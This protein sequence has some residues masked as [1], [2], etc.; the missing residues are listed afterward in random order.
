MVAPCSTFLPIIV[1]VISG[2][3]QR[4]RTYIL[5]IGKVTQEQ[6][7]C[8]CHHIGCEVKLI[9]QCRKLFPTYWSTAEKWDDILALCPLSACPICG[10]ISLN[11]CLEPHETLWDS[12][13]R[14]W[15]VCDSNIFSLKSLLSVLEFLCFVKW[16]IPACFYIESPITPPHHM[17][18]NTQYQWPLTYITCV[19]WVM[20]SPA[21]LLWSLF[22][23]LEY[24][25]IK[26][27]A[28]VWNDL[29]R[30]GICTEF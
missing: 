11:C 4:N 13:Q 27:A 10:C 2:P 24:F 18:Y 7:Q 25:R 9:L 5:N 6:W 28:M 15:K 26:T 22:D 1:V 21:F 19:I 3:E 14:H 29:F 23:Q 30:F 17:E 20:E 16:H 8:S 12:L